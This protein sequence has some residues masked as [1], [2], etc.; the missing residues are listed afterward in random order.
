MIVFNYQ[1]WIVLSVEMW[2]VGLIVFFFF[3]VCQ[4]VMLGWLFFRLRAEI[5]REI[6]QPKF[7]RLKLHRTYYTVLFSNKFLIVLFCCF[8]YC[9]ILK[10]ISW[11]KIFKWNNY[12]GDKDI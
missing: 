12:V 7:F 5:A 1:L 3:F 9:V 8:F 2:I 6:A 11:G 10:K 4:G